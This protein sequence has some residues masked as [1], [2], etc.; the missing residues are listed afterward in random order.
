MHSHHEAE[1]KGLAD[2]QAQGVYACRTEGSCIVFGLYS[3]EP[4]GTCDCGV[5]R[6]CGVITCCNRKGTSTTMAA[7]TTCRGTCCGSVSVIRAAVR[8]LSAGRYR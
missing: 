8:P 7:Y 1:G 6:D 5:T 2:A 4:F 3:V